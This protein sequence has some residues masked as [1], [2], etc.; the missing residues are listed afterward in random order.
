MNEHAHSYNLATD[1]CEVDGC[2]RMRP[3]WLDPE[4]IAVGHA[5]R[6]AAETSGGSPFKMTTMRY[7]LLMLALLAVVHLG[8][9]AWSDKVA[10]P[11][12]PGFGDV[13]VSVTTD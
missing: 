4:A 3:D 13:S 2:E 12:E 7:V 5:P 9:R 8:A 10:A 6:Q 11:T 1:M